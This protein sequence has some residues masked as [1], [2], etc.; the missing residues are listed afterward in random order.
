MRSQTEFTKMFCCHS[1]NNSPHIITNKC[2]TFAFSIL[3]KEVLIKC[4]TP[5]HMHIFARVLS[6]QKG[7]IVFIGNCHVYR[8][9]CLHPQASLHHHQTLSSLRDITIW[10]VIFDISRWWNG[11]S[12]LKIDQFYYFE[13]AFYTNGFIQSLFTFYLFSNDTVCI[14]VFT[15]AYSSIYIC[16]HRTS[17]HCPCISLFLYFLQF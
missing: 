5:K 17:D 2:I 6:L 9:H 7:V 13:I 1:S 3:G 8:K 12:L 10:R 11:D 16:L 15:Y 4:S 14:N